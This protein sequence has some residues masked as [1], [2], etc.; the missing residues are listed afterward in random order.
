VPSEIERHLDWRDCFNVRD[1]GGLRTATGRETRRRAVVRADT[2]V[3][4]DD[5]AADSELSDAGLG[6]AEL[7]MLQVRL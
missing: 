2:L 5:I 4:P 3:P 6:E 1:L 7:D